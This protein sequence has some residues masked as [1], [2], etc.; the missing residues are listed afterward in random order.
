MK[1]IAISI[2]IGI[3]ITTSVVSFGEG[4]SE[5]LAED[6]VRLHIVANSDSETDQSVKLK[7]R[8]K[9]LEEMKNFSE[10]EEIGDNLA[11]FE[12][13]ANS[14][15]QREGLPYKA[16]AH[17][18]IFQFPTKY[19]DGFAL[20]KGEYTALKIDL[21]DGAGQNWWCVL[22]PPLCMVDAATEDFDLL[23]KTTFKDN[24]S[25][26]SDNENIQFKIEF[27]LAELF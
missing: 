16:K 15:L 12:D 26:V 2:L 18:G 5:E 11:F 24:Y 17:F 25:V 10:I 27:K 22:F 7:I 4:L 14:V 21:G 9:I 23:L 1:K 6:I 8:D 13:V 19:Y 20:P 3:L